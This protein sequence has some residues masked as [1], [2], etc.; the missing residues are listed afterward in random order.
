MPKLPVATVAPV[1]LLFACTG[2]ALHVDNPDH[3]TVFVD[4]VHTH[5]PTLP[6]R[7]YGTTRWNALPKAPAGDRAD[8][9]SLPSSQ[10]VAIPVPVSGW[11]FPLDFPLELLA[12]LANGRAD[13]RTAIAVQK[14]P[15]EVRTTDE[16]ANAELD[17]LAARA[18]AARNSR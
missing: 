16:V 10:T 2:P 17:P 15:V 11:L 12:R 9:S 8:F 1:F 5:A 3:H 13:V 14:A 4:G 18:T 6:F 7:Y